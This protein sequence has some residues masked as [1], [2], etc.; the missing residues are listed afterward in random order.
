[1]NNSLTLRDT[2]QET[3]KALKRIDNISNIIRKIGVI[4]LWPEQPVAEHENVERIR[5]AAASVGVELVELD[6]NGFILNS[7]GIMVS[8]NDVDFV[9]HL[10]YETAKSYDV[11]SIAA[12]WNPID[13]YIEWGFDTYWANQMSHNIYSYTGS[14]KI[15]SLI[16]QNRG[17]DTASTMAMFNHTLSEPVYL[18]S[19]RR[20]LSIFYCGINWEKL[21]GKPG[22]HEGVLRGLDKAGKLSLYGPEKVR[23]INVWEGYRN[24]SGSLPFDGRTVIEKI[25]EAG[26]CLVFSSEAHKSSEIMSNRLFEALSGGAVIIGDE[27]NFISEAIGNNYIKVP[28]SLSTD[29]RIGNIL[30]E[31]K[32]L[33]NDPEVAQK[34]AKDAQDKF[35][36][37]YI[38]TSQIANLYESFK[39][40]R[41]SSNK[42][43]ESITHKV[44][45]IIAQPYDHDGEHVVNYLEKLNKGF[46][47][48]ANIL[49]LCSA[50]NEDW[51][52]SHC[53]SYVTV[54]GALNNEQEILAPA[55]AVQI[56]QK[57]LQTSKIWFSSLVEDVF[58]HQF[59]ESVVA[60]KDHYIGRMGHLLHHIEPDGKKNYDYRSGDIPVEKMHEASKGSIIFDAGWLIDSIR[61]P[62]T[63]WKDCLIIAEYEERTIACSQTSALIIPIRPIEIFAEK[64][65]S[66]KSNT[67]G[68]SFTLRHVTKRKSITSDCFVKSYSTQIDNYN[69]NNSIIRFNTESKNDCSKILGSGW[70][71]IEQHH[72][73][74]AGSKAELWVKVRPFIRKVKF[75]I[76]GNPHVAI[77]KQQVM[78][79]VNNIQIATAKIEGDKVISIELETS[80]ECWNND[81]LNKI[82]ISVSD[83]AIPTGGSTDKRVLGVSLKSIEIT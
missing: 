41:D 71:D 63:G 43:I 10:H 51:Y 68:S 11:P 83:V 26:A 17:E 36:Q 16:A 31:I 2:S 6:R 56:L 78:I 55:D 39:D 22:R 66:E 75:N 64:G 32:Q 48:R 61:I 80:K 81:Q 40:Y 59:I 60:F 58:Y 79:L 5:S 42:I 30:K 3:Q 46:D 53:G 27:H 45:D 70:H 4:R 65:F 29:Q 54:V 82:T 62:K 57:Y 44:V 33:E 1:M 47:G 73:W 72:V 18:P 14:K 15:K 21:T 67:R 20:S 77:R 9:L 12:L 13:F 49:L 74:S 28:S 19:K 25:A 37:K 52:K 34:M 50:K 69:I 24:Y 23:D 7:P 38:L 35:I 8:K 76:G